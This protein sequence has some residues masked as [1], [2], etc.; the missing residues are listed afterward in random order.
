MPQREVLPH[1]CEPR[2]ETKQCQ[3]AGRGQ[4]MQNMTRTEN[5]RPRATWKLLP[6]SWWFCKLSDT[7]PSKPHT[8]GHQLTPACSWGD[9]RVSQLLGSARRNSNTTPP[10][11][12]TADAGMLLRSRPPQIRSRCGMLVTKVRPANCSAPVPTWER[13]RSK[14]DLRMWGTPGAAGNHPCWQQEMPGC[15]DYCR[16]RTPWLAALVC[17]HYCPQTSHPVPPHPCEP[18]RENHPIPSYLVLLLSYLSPLK[19]M[20]TKACT[21][22]GP[23]QPPAAHPAADM[24]LV[25]PPSLTADQP[26]LL[27]GVYVTALGLTMWGVLAAASP[28]I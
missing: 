23:A 12:P 10:R 8:L 11:V 3:Q 5:P 28:R 15:S 7:S 24:V 13:E 6:S 22:H 9:T 20:L 1:P 26:S 2:R 14:R 4:P 25:C 21:P 17:G 27:R 18:R 19:P 16:A